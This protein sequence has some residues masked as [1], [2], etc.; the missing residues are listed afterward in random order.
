MIEKVRKFCF[1]F[2][3]FAWQFSSAS[4]KTTTFQI[5][6]FNKILLEDGIQSAKLT[7]VKKQLHIEILHSKNQFNRLNLKF[8]DCT[9]RQ[10]MDKQVSVS[11]KA[12]SIF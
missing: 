1:D 10:K 4:S 3:P 11:R 6:I 2:F 5:N 9:Y 8:S 12:C 7:V